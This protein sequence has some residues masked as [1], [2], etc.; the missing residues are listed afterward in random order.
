MYILVRQKDNIIIGTAMKPIDEKTAS[1]N[2]YRV[3]EIEQSEFKP[4]MIGS[5]LTSFEQG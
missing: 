2:G 4:S 5:V 3:Y 1:T